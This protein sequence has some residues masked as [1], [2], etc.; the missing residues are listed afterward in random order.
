[1]LFV[2]SSNDADKKDVT[3]VNVQSGAIV[4]DSSDVTENVD[5]LE[6]MLGDDEKQEV[7]IIAE[8]EDNTEE[9]QWFFSKLFGSSKDKQEESNEVENQTEDKNDENENK[10][11][12]EVEV[13]TEG[14]E[15]EKQW[16]FSK[17][18]KKDDPS[19][20]INNQNTSREDA[21]LVK[22]TW[23]DQS[24]DNDI[25]NISKYAPEVLKTDIVYPGINL[26][27]QPGKKFEV[28][29]HSLKLNNKY[30]NETLA[31]MLKGDIVRQITSENAYGCFEV[32]LMTSAL[33]KNIGKTGYVCKKYLQDLQDDSIDQSNIVEENK[34][35][36]TESTNE[37]E[38]TQE[39]ETSKNIPK[40][41]IG[42][43]IKIQK[44]KAVFGDITLIAGDCVDQMTEIDE[45]GCF[46]AHVY[47]TSIQDSIGKV[48][49]ICVSDI[50]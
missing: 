46:M 4:V 20:N 16:F 1:M 33:K 49:R 35:E 28:G 31:Y 32:E 2:I 25:A 27:T 8:D 13:E 34:A 37:S 3:E 36:N 45:Q 15:K 21:N 19:D 22:N 18:F 44:P 50:Y 17:I 29:V 42:D 14:Q 26:E 43:I 47:Q 10:D 41:N 23:S 11:I 7:E 38:D 12:V 39:N 6:D 48:G 40:T 5:V 9:K 30:F 24:S